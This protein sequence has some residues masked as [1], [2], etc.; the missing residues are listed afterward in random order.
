MESYFV[1]SGQSYPRD[2]TMA[3]GDA[4][5]RTLPQPA[6]GRLPRT[7]A[8]PTTRS[9]T[10]DAPLHPS[11]VPGTQYV[12]QISHRN[13]WNTPCFNTL[14]HRIVPIVLV[15]ICSAMARPAQGDEDIDLNPDSPAF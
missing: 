14:I 8:S 15:S 13:P 7:V 6:D 10:P 9:D 1:K 12:P 2:S 3:G 11:K 5:H 4:P